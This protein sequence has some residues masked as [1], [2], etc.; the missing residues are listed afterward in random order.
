MEISLKSVNFPLKRAILFWFSEILLCLLFLNI[1][2]P[3]IIFMPKRHILGVSYS[4][5]LDMLMHSSTEGLPEF[6]KFLAI[7]NRAAVH[8][9]MLFFV[10]TVFQSSCL[11]T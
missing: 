4:A 8:S 7:R 10:W 2:Q 5:P 9:C 3:P 1:N 11:N 6:L